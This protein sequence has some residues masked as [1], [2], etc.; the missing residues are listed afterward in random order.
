MS[1]KIAKILVVDDE[2]DIRLIIRELIL[3]NYP[4]IILEASNGQEANWKLANDVFDVLITDLRMPRFTG[5][6]L[7]K[8]ISTKDPKDRPK[9]I[10]ILS[11]VID[12]QLAKQLNEKKVTTLLKPLNEKDLFGI[13][14]EV[15][16]KKVAA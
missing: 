8:T 3:E 10:I 14:D 16:E 7:L 15:I 2:P 4:A 5:I 6:E 1:E 11:G 12:N 13:L 9:K